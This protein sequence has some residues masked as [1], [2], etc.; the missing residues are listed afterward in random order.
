MYVEEY[1]LLCCNPVN[2]GRSPQKCRKN[3][4]PPSS[5]SISNLVSPPIYCWF[6]TLRPCRWRRYLPPKQWWTYTEIQDVAA[7][8]FAPFIVT[9][10][11]IWLSKNW[12][13]F[14]S[15]GI[16]SCYLAVIPPMLSAAVIMFAVATADQLPCHP[17]IPP[18]RHVAPIPSHAN[19]FHTPRISYFRAY[20]CG[21]QTR[22]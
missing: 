16:Q 13:K 11:R 1:E 9:A 3:Q 8:K 22:C 12:R 6:L 14:F 21:I 19:A 17:L 5:G 15:F 10:A 18:S 7:Q 20:Y 2:F 4:M